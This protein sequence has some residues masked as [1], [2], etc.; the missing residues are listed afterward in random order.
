MHSHLTQLLP[1]TFP[2]AMHPYGLQRNHNCYLEKSNQWSPNSVSSLLNH[3]CSVTNRKDK[4]CTT[5]WRGF[6]S[7]FPLSFQRTNRKYPLN[8]RLHWTCVINY[9]D[10]ISLWPS[11]WTHKLYIICANIKWISFRFYIQ[12]NAMIFHYANSVAD[13]R[14]HIF[15]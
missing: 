14:G 12:C 13:T 11:L 3:S 7:P 6:Q 2:W 5:R 4:H 8:W 1:Y 9:M 15:T 10:D